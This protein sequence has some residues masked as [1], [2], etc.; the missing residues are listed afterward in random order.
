M[1]KEEL[2]SGAKKFMKNKGYKKR[3]TTWV[4]QA[5]DDIFV[6]VNIQSSQ[7]DKS[8]FYINLG[9]YISSLGSKEIPSI[10]DCHMS[11]RVNTSVDSTSV[12]ENIVEKWE[13]WYGSQ[14]AIY[15]KVIERKMPMFTNKQVYGYF[16][17]KGH[18]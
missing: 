18:G 11:E 15:E 17:V 9:V 3:N 5:D 1:T 6:V 14:S 4:K 8:I 16:L 12:F 2:V 13:Q 10:H 7:Y